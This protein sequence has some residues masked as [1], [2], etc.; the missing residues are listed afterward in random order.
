MA[1]KATLLGTLVYGAML[2]YVLA[3]VTLA[4]RLRRAGGALY[5]AG[6]VA[7]VAAWVVRW[8]R[9][10]HVPLQNLFEVFMCMGVVVYPV[11]MFC[12]RFLR[13]GGEAAD[14]LI[15]AMVLFPVGFVFRAEPHRL[16]PALQ[17]GLFAPHVAAYM[18][19]YVIMA[20]AGVQAL[21]RLLIGED[22]DAG[23]IPYELGTY[24]VVRLGF[25]LLTV[26]LLLGAW[27]G[28]LA[29]SDYWNWDPKELWSL[30]SWLVFVG[31][32]HFRHMFGARH[33]RANSMMAIGGLATIVI[34]LLWVNLS[35]ILAG[36]HSYAR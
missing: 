12:R 2:A 6:F 27:W 30:A 36:L 32:F 19:A 9:V 15:G 7:A 22:G 25:P 5:L 3:S 1:I 34:T 18:F 20:K 29:W 35:R 21:G 10:G 8:C 13:V 17:C 31:Y 23:H 24:K 26:G 4:F 33:A 28:K 11:T 14:A 16:P